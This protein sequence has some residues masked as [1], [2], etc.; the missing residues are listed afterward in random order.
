MTEYVPYEPEQENAAT[1]YVPYTPGEET[2]KQAGRSTRDELARQ[3][4]LFARH[5]V[6]GVSGVGGAMAD[7][8]HGAANLMGAGLKGPRPSEA[9]QQAMT[10]L[11]LPTADTPLEKGVGFGS[12]IVA[13]AMDP[14]AIA[15]QAAIAAK[16]APAAFRTA[17]EHD[18]ELAQQLRAQG[19][20]LL[21][22]QAGG[23][24]FTQAL[25]GLGGTSRVA[26]SLKYD[27][28][29]VMQGL[30]RAENK[31]PADAPL[32][33]EVLQAQVKAIAKDGYD[34]VEN[35]QRLPI[36]GLMRGE[37][38]KIQRELGTNDS[39]PRAQRD[40]VLQEVQKYMFDAQGRLNQQFTGR[41]AITAIKTLRQEATDLFHMEGGNK[42]LAA[43]KERI[44][45]T[46]EKQIERTLN[47]GG[48]AGTEM[49]ENFKAARVQMAKNYATQK[50][51]ADPESG[52]IDAAK[53]ASAYRSGTKL[54][55]N[56]KTIA[57]AGAPPFRASTAV[58]RFG[59][60]PATTPWD[61]LLMTVGGAGMASG[62]SPQIGGAML[63]YPIA[64]MGAR[65]AIESN[66]GQKTMGSSGLFGPD[67]AARMKMGAAGTMA[68]YANLFDPYSQ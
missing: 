49:L 26:E 37:L 59:D 27:N 34:P 45:M 50:M 3:M 39:F 28:Q 7:F 14:A 35:L 38:R 19:I 51:L 10:R 67:V 43:A 25:Q 2:K 17:K 30:A 55:G 48:R 24:K 58:P 47:A 52:F 8:G 33:R 40:E 36:G 4:G 65:K 42:S 32:T 29:R 64:R 20:K 46:L 63:A 31:L 68:P 56:L 44:A 16:G 18:I 57:D 61:D 15:G 22:S 1:Q 6:T 21:P 5:A 23:G 9:M 41:D 53:A 13:G 12:Q 11:G 62:G 60:T 54:T 66:V